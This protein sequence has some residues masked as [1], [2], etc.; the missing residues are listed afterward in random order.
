MPALFTPFALHHQSTP[1]DQPDSTK[2]Q[3]DMTEAIKQLPPIGQARHMFDHFVKTLQPTFGI[4]HIPSTRSIMEKTYQ[5]MLDGEQPTPTNLMLLFSIFSG[6]AL[7]W[8]PYLLRQLNATQDE[9]RAAFN[10]YSLLAT[11]ILEHPLEP[12]QPSTT[13]I[14][15]IATLG[16]LLANTVGFSIKIGLL[17]TRCFLMAQALQ[18]HR[19]DTVQAQE[20]RRVKG[21]DMIDIEVQRRFWWNMVATDWYIA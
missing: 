2:E 8:S 18:I 1:D 17:Q 20:E 10:T 15:A 19:L 6:A 5:G 13:A 14:V 3:A 21:C 4:L 16:H 7:V 12:V 9:A 11:S